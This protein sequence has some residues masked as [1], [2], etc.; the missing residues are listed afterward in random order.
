MTSK[1]LQP[2]LGLDSRREQLAEAN[3]DDRPCHKPLGA[4][5]YGRESKGLGDGPSLGVKTKGKRM[6][7][8]WCTV[9]YV[10]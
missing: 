2:A 1:T 7:K 6:V 4:G 10:S 5:C 9:L 3:A 8:H